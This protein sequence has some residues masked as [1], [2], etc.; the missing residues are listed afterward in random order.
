M[1]RDRQRVCLS[2]ATANVVVCETTPRSDG[3]GREP[4]LTAGIQRDLRNKDN[5]AV[6]TVLEILERRLG[7]YQGC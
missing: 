1:A 7:V 5:G 3:V 4:Y 2:A 6:Q